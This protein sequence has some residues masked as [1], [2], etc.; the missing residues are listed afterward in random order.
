MKEMCSLKTEINIKYLGFPKRN[1]SIKY[2]RFV[3]KI[4]I[5]VVFSVIYSLN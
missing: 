3:E 5:I 2:T 4:N 1:I